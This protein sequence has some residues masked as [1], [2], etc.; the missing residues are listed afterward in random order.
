MIKKFLY[1][2]N[3]N[4]K[5]SLLL[6]SGFMFISTI[7]EMIGLKNRFHHQPGK[8]SGGEQQRIAVARSVILEPKL[9]LADEPTGNLDPYT[10][11]EIEDILLRFNKE[12]CM[13]LIIATHNR[14]FASRIGHQME[15]RDGQLLL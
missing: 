3:K 6:L 2:F 9:I 13:T 4:Q 11:T 15:L 8:L 7:L 12:N 10:A 5:T 1:F 14:K